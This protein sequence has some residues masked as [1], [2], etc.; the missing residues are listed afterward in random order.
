MIGKFAWSKAISNKIARIALN[1]TGRTEHSCST[2]SAR[3]YIYAHSLVH[4]S[5]KQM[6]PQRSS[7]TTIDSIHMPTLLA[8]SYEFIENS[9]EKQF[10]KFLEQ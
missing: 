2:S 4:R 6:A 8:V 10:Y 9:A 1:V 5:T 7:F 3:K